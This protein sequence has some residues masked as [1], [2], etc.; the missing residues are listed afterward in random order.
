MRARPRLARTSIAI[1]AAAAAAIAA[2]QLWISP[3]GIA[4]R[5]RFHLGRAQAHLASREIQ[6]ARGDLRAALRLQPGNGA[7]KELAALELEGGNWELAFIELKSSTELHPEDPDGWIRLARLMVDRGWIEAPEAA[8]DRA[9]EAAP[10][11]ADAHA[12][13]AELRFRLGRYHGARADADA[14]LASATQGSDAARSAH[15][16]LER[17]AL[18]TGSTAGAT[19]GADTP[20]P[21][22]PRHL[23]AETQIDVGSLS[24]WSREEWPGRLGE[25]REQLQGFLGEKRWGDA[26]RLIDIAKRSFPGAVF[27]PYLAGILE[28]TRGD[29]DAAERHLAEALAL[30]PRN[31]TVAAAL[32]RT[33]SL[34]KE[35]S[36]AGDQL[37]KIAERDHSFAFVRYLAA[38]AYVE[39]RDPI[40]AET[41]LRRGLSLQPDSPVPYQH[42][43]DY[44]F[45]LD[46]APEALDICEQGLGRFP[47]AVALRM[48]LAQISSSAGRTAEAIRAYE[49]VLEERPDQDVV[50][51]RLAML[52]ASRDNDPAALQ[53][54]AQVHRDLQADQPSDPLLDDVLGWLHYRVGDRRARALLETAVQVAPGEPRPHFHLAAVYARERK[55]ERA[56]SELQAALASGRAFPERLEAMRLLR[57]NQSPGS[58]NTSIA[59]AGN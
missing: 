36:F 6:Q 2:W 27:A 31:P 15:R 55:P 13:R 17:V 33:W 35:S 9:L 10:R 50:E 48:I 26:Q 34:R 40:H 4:R 45:G 19:A 56:R 49:A 11:Q 7:R 1:A 24:S 32:A 20:P 47:H 29:L 59:P 51:Y 42:L 41:A 23:R 53:R 37:M 18:R 46:R 22:A 8:L 39:A 30:A 14:A 54:M 3:F 52:L 43:A 57:E 58:A 5:A 16:T 12:Q 21:A 28:F 25:M 38:R 44:Y